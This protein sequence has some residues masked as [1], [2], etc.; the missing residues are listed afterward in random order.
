MFDDAQNQKEALKLGRCSTRELPENP[1][2]KINSKSGEQID[3]VSVGMQRYQS[4]N[5]AK[6]IEF[7][8]L[9]SVKV[10]SSNFGGLLVFLVQ[11]P[12]N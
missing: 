11:G 1:V 5:G 8:H 9:K 2:F 3:S 6:L 7:R 10:S 4:Q 12:I